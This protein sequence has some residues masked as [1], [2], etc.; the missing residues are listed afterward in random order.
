[1]KIRRSVALA[2]PPVPGWEPS[3]AG[4]AYH[5]LE[6]MI[7]TLVLPPG[8]TLS[9]AILSARTGIGRTPIREALKRLEHQGLVTS[10][11][12]KGL[13]VRDMKVEDQFTLLEVLRPLDRLIAIKAAQ[14]VLEPQREALRACAAAMRKAAAERNLHAFLRCDQ[15]CDAI[16]YEAARNHFA[17]DIVTPLYSHCRRFWCSFG[18]DGQLVQVAELHQDLMDAVADGDPDR[19]AAASDALI[20]H[21]EAFSRGVLGFRDRPAKSSIP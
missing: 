21:L 6:E 5:L 3:L 14:W 8:A 1:M 18:R 19:A 11:P 13:I 16:I 15:E 2:K 10:L 17:I 7:V 20:D 4:Q 9:E 12:R